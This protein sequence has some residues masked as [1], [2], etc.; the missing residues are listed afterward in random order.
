MLLK[1]WLHVLNSTRCE[2]E[3]EWQLQTPSAVS[4]EDF[5]LAYAFY[6]SQDMPWHGQVRNTNRISLAQDLTNHFFFA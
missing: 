2:Y 3:V 4:E 5:W 6:G 1:T